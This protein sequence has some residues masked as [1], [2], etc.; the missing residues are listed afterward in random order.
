[1]QTRIVRVTMADG[2]S[3]KQKSYLRRTKNKVE[4]KRAK[5]D[6][7][8]FPGYGRYRGWWT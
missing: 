3:S 6:P 7:E 5:Q 2:G 4:R 1:M 8:C